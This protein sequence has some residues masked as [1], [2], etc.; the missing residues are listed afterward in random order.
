[1]IDYLKPDLDEIYGI[2]PYRMVRPFAAWAERR[3]PHGRPTLGQLVKTTT[4]SGYLRVWLL[5]RCRRLRPTSYRAHHEHARMERWL[6][7]VSRAASLDVDLAREVAGAAALVKGYGE[8]R[9]RMTA[10]FDDLLASAFRAAELSTARGDVTIARNLARRYRA[11]VREG[12]DGEAEAAALARA[13]ITRLDA[14]DV[15]GARTLLDSPG[16]RAV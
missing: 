6:T 10:V 5:A 4:V 3:W 9:R 11:R 16:P 15:G 12:P 13:V 2:L 1:M 14:G 7:A 8:V